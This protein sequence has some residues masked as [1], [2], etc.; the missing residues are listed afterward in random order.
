MN[1]DYPIL[2]A[3]T[4]SETKAY[5]VLIYLCFL[6]RHRCCTARFLTLCLGRVNIADIGFKVGVASMAIGAVPGTTYSSAS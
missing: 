2:L 5:P 3:A 6:L 4:A 1:S